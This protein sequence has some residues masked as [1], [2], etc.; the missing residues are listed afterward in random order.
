VV[1][2]SATQPRDHGFEPIS[3]HNLVS[4][5]GITDYA[6]LIELQQQLLN[7]KYNYY[8]SESFYS[9]LIFLYE[10]NLHQKESMQEAKLVFLD[11]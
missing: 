11:G 5:Q 4:Q 1:K 9:Y 2:V 6:I 8:N 3:G 10:N 7:A